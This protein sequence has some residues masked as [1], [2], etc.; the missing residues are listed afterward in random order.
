MNST[1]AFAVRDVH[2]VFFSSDRAVHALTNINLDIE[3]GSFT[4]ILGPSGCGKSTLLRILGGLE[5]PTSGSVETAALGGE[6]VPASAYVFQDHGVFPW[7]T[8]ADNVSFGLE[9]AGVKKK[10][11]RD[12]AMQ[13][14]SKVGMEQFATAYPEQLSG[15]MRQRVAI[16][17]AFATGS[18]YLL[19][20]EP[21][22]ALDAQTRRVMQEQLLQLWQEEQKTVVL[23]THA[24]EEALL[25]GD[26]VITMTARPG[27]VKEDDV[28]PFVRPRSLDLEGDSGFIAMK[29]RIWRTLRTEVNESLGVSA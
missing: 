27:Q 25:L 18:P 23:V 8:V 22:G 17:R 24:I 3:T 15:G 9:M 2:K 13:W 14:L 19:M 7:L 26:R 10:E 1:V 28:V 29:S 6:E 5:K 11:R 16:A 4:C 20:D 12:I 21:L